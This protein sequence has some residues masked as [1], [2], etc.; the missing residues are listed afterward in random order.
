MSREE[1][2]NI[3][4]YYRNVLKSVSEFREYIAIA[5]SA[6][7]CIGDSKWGIAI[8]KKALQLADN[9]HDCY[10]VFERISSLTI[11]GRI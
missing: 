1:A 10:E 7:R 11:Y 2:R 6:V 9:D 8:M 4:A 3:K 5:D